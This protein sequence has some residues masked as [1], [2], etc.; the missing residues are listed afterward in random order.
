MTDAEFDALVDRV[1]KHVWE[2]TKRST[3]TTAKFTRYE[4]WCASDPIGQ[5]EWEAIVDRAM[6][7]AMERP[8]T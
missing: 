2:E 8:R 7:K 5:D 6:R 4:D 1:A 3:P